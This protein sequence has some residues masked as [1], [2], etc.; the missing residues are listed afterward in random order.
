MKRC[1]FSDR[2]GREAQVFRIGMGGA[3]KLLPS[4]LE[5]LVT[6]LQFRKSGQGSYQDEGQ[7]VVGRNRYSS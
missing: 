1:S 3:L 6:A 5:T 2:L 4:S 7:S